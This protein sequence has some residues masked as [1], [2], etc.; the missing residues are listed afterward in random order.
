MKLKCTI[1]LTILFIIGFL[2]LWLIYIYILLLLGILQLVI[3]FKKYYKVS[4][5]VFACRCRYAYDDM[6]PHITV[7]INI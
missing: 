1:S 3:A 4:Y 2:M 6:H 7:V 5:N